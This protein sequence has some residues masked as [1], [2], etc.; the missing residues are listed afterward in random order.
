MALRNLALNQGMDFQVLTL[1]GYIAQ[2][3]DRAGTTDTSES[4]R[5]KGAIAL[6]G[7]LNQRCATY[8]P[9][10]TLLAI[11]ETSPWFYPRGLVRPDG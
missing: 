2:R 4:S 10:D 5:P 7:L 8:Y 1:L 9:Y 3:K 11:A 6:A